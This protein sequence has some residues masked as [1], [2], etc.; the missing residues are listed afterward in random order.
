[1]VR[2]C[3]LLQLI[4]TNLGIL[5]AIDDELSHTLVDI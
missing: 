2:A 1:M 5:E 3:V 4:L